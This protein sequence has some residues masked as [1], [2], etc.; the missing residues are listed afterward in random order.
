[1]SQGRVDIPLNGNGVQQAHAVAALLRGRGIA[2]IVAS[3][4]ARARVT[5][6]IVAAAI[7]VATQ[8]DDDLREVAFG[9]QEG[10]PMQPWFNDWI[11]GNFTPTGAE[12]FTALRRRA[13]MTMNRL[14]LAPGPLLAVGHGAFF[15]ALRTAMGLAPDVRLPNAVPLLCEPDGTTWRLTHP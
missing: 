8:F 5:A 10:Q 1:M 6:E 15:R 2:A 11:A 3:P 13:V 4:L 9:A 7:G 14:L 12:P